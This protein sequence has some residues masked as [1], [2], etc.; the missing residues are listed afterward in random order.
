MKN[1]IKQKR[2][3]NKM[4]SKY[5]NNNNIQD[6]KLRHSTIPKI[7]YYNFLNEN[8]LDKEEKKL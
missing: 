4:I 7:P 5:Q 6:N 2:N 8:L 3:Y 1:K